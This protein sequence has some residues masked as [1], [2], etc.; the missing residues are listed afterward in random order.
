[1]RDEKHRRRARASKRGSWV[2]WMVAGALV[3]G[4]FDICYATGFSYWRSGI[5]PS[6]ILQFV[7]SGALGPDAFEGGATTAAIGLGFHYL[8]AFIITAIFF[9]AAAER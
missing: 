3:A 6:R 4:T 8:N 2:T 1:M 5:P 9:A 7:A